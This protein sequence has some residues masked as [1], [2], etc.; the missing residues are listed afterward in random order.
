MEDATGITSVFDFKL[1]LPSRDSHAAPNSGDAPGDAASDPAS[2][3]AALYRT[4]WHALQDQSDPGRNSV[5]IIRFRWNRR[6]FRPN[7][8]LSGH[9]IRQ[10]ILPNPPVSPVDISSENPVTGCIFMK[11][12]IKPRVPF[13]LPV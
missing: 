5:M 6:P 11:T 3:E 13:F 4:R 1:E 8:N 10:W 2:F 7:P 9:F 12:V